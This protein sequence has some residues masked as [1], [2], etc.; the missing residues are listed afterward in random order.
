VSEVSQRVCKGRVE[1][2]V[3]K[4]DGRKGGEKEDF[5]RDKC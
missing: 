5:L 4:D 1:V 3:T 2:K